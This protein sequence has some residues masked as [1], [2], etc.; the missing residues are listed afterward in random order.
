MSYSFN[1]DYNSDMD[2]TFIYQ[3]DDKD[4]QVQ[5]T[6]KRVKNINYRYKDGVFFV[7][8]SRF[9]SISAIKSGLDKFAKRLIKRTPTRKGETEEY[10]YIF[11]DKYDLSFPGEISFPSGDKFIYKTIEDLHKKLKKWFLNYMTGETN[12][13]AVIMSAPQYRV[14]VRKMVS[15]YGTN[16]RQTKSITYSLTLIHYSPEIIE[17]VIVHELTHCFVF[18]HSDNFYRLLYKYS[19]NYDILRKKLIK[20]EF[21]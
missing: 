6:Y 5:I 15:R 8:C 20:A 14:K 12:K 17:S 19:P 13:M 2:K 9:R 1:S 11:G 10:I 21:K 7:S 4:Y 18:N 16:S 3:V